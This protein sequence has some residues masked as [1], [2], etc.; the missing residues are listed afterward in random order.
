MS[1]LRR[2]GITEMGFW[3]SKGPLESW[4][5]AVSNEKQILGKEQR[6]AKL[7]ADMGVKGGRSLRRKRGPKP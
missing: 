2:D 1:L 7:R 5:N 6:S 4:R 3:F